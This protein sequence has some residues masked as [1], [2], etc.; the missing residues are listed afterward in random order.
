MRREQFSLSAREQLGPLEGN[1]LSNFFRSTLS[2][3][4]L[5]SAEMLT[6]TMPIIRIIWNV[7]VFPVMLQSFGSI[8]TSAGVTSDAFEKSLSLAN[9]N[10]GKV[11]EKFIFIE[12][13]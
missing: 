5:I 12:S 9:E 4:K 11:G 6:N 13:I 3:Y 10:S 2:M 7:S 8:I 1:V